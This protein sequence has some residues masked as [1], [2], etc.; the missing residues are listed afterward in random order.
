MK[1][2]AILLTLVL[3]LA[4]PS[5]AQTDQQLMQEL[6]V[7]AQIACSNYATSKSMIDIAQM[8]GNNQQYQL[9]VYE[10]QYAEQFYNYLEG[11]AQN[12]A[13]LRTPGGYQQY[14]AS[15]MEYCYRTK[16]RDYRSYEEI[17][18]NL[19]QWVAQRQWEVSTPEGQQSYYARRQLEEQNFQ[20]SQQRIRDNNAAFDSYMQGLRQADAQRDKY[21][22]QYVNTIHDQYEYV[23][24]YDGQSYLYP[25]TQTTNPVMQNPD[26]SYTELVPYE[27]Y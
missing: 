8:A 27:K 12:L 15:L 9:A 2:K 13:S 23:N 4:G 14:Q 24:P 17:L 16:F 21:H 18:P 26:G 5:W 25:N 22:H 10:M 11:L 7:S 3:M 19:Q 1:L 6:Q 20:A